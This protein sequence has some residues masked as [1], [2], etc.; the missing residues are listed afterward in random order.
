MRLRVDN[1]HGAQSRRRHARHA[2]Y[3]GDGNHT[4]GPAVI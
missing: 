3:D 2:G 4:N 1:G